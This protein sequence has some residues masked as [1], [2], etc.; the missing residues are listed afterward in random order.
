LG[1]GGSNLS[2]SNERKHYKKL[3]SYL[4]NSMSDLFQ[5]SLNGRG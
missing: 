2:A 3:T 4:V 1:N 5:R